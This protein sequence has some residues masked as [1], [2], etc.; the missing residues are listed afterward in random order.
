MIMATWKPKRNKYN[1]RKTEY[2]G[3]M[4]DSKGEA[5]LAAQ[6][7]A[8]I[9]IGKVTGVE[10]QR[11]FDLIGANG[12]K[13]GT[14]RVDFVLTFADGHREV[15]E[16]KGCPSRDWSLRKK[17]FCDNYPSIPYR[18]FGNKKLAA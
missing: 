13:I 6:I 8:L 18:V 14:H 16:Y 5:G 7:D 1:A 2:R 17:L 10:R 12:S 9:A 15:Y 3:V 11:R 4:Y